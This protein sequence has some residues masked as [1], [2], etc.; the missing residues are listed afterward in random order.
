M[1]N[2][3]QAIFQS[4]LKQDDSILPVRPDLIHHFEGGF[5]NPAVAPGNPSLNYRKPMYQSLN[6]PRQFGAAT[7]PDR[8]YRAVVVS[9]S[10]SIP[11]K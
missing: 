8:S 4:M 9:T 11:C 5:V 10:S 7:T 1:A 2:S 3:R 6:K